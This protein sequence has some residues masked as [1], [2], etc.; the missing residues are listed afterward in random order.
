LRDGG[1]KRTRP[2]GYGLRALRHRQFGILVTT[3]HVAIQAYEEIKEDQHPIVII[4]ARDIVRILKAG[5][6]SS[7]DDLKKWLSAL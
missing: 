5:G 3:S 1:V 7:R 6:I 2:T 4:A